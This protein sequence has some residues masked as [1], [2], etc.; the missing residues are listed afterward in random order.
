MQRPPSTPCRGFKDGICGIK[1]PPIL[2]SKVSCCSLVK[3]FLFVCTHFQP[4][5]L[6]QNPCEAEVAVRNSCYGFLE[7]DVVFSMIHDFERNFVAGT[8]RLVP[9][10]GEQ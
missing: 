5:Y 2:Y 7:T 4:H 6:V 1:A 10:S 3:S 9:F 8:T